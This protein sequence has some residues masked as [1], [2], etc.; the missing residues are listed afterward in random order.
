MIDP[1]V[2]IIGQPTIHDS[3]RIDAFCVITNN[4]IIESLVHVATG[5]RLIGSSGRIHLGVGSFVSM[6]STI[7]TGSDNYSTGHLISPVFP[8]D[9]R[10]IHS[11]DVT[12]EAFSGIGA[13]TLI[14]PGVTI[15]WGATVG[16]C[17]LVTKNIPSGEVWAGIPARKVKDRDL[18]RLKQTIAEYER[19]IQQ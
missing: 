1:M 14:L 11:G 9:L 2:R 19:R 3:A 10:N 4:V 5:V 13:H 12:L 17:S 18:V 7:L 6:G 15:G 16:A 8:N